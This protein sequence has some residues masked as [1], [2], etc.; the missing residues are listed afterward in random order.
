METLAHGRYRLLGLRQ[1]VVTRRSKIK[2]RHIFRFVFPAL[3]V[4]PVPQDAVLINDKT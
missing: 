3:E 4:F 2:R 1:R